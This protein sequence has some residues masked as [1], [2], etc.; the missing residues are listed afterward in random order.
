MSNFLRNHI[1][2]T[3]R[4]AIIAIVLLLTGST[5][6]DY[7][8]FR[9]GKPREEI[10][11]RELVITNHVDVTNEVVERHHQYVTETN[12]VWQTNEAAVTSLAAAT[13]APG[14][15]FAAG[16]KY[17]VL[18]FQRSQE[19][20]L[21]KLEAGARDL[22]QAVEAEGGSN[23]LS[24]AY[25]R[26]YPRGSYEE[27]V[28]AGVAILTEVIRRNATN[29][30]LSDIKAAAFAAKIRQ[31]DGVAGRPAAPPP[32]PMAQPPPAPVPATN[33]PAQK[34]KKK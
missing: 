25:Q 4:A 31:E 23:L 34:G 32:Q 21:P 12:L 28:E 2:L 13:N 18:F 27:G 8:T 6:I 11:F 26:A 16:V 7:L 30:T 1:H 33:A 10:K 19:P 24:A 29:V 9:P 17:G 3:G 20:S 5:L 22:W 14:P 15:D